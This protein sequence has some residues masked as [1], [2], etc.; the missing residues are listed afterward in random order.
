MYKF[1]NRADNDVFR[2]INK[3]KLLLTSVCLIGKIDAKLQTQI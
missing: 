3:A 2:A 1:L